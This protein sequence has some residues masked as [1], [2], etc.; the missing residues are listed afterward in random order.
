MH[1]QRDTDP[2][3]IA[4]STAQPWTTLHITRTHAVGYAVPAPSYRT[5]GKTGGGCGPIIIKR[6][7]VVGSFP[8]PFPLGVPVLF[9]DGETT[10]GVACAVQDSGATAPL[11]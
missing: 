7:N 11:L 1:K 8:L 10:R 6:R 9:T 4:L 5:G 3:G 2:R